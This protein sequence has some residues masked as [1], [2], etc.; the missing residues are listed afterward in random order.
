MVKGLTQG[1]NS[2]SSGG[3][4]GIWTHDLLKNN[5]ELLVSESPLHNFVLGF[6]T[7]R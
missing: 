1:R 7:R 3:S 6:H 5:S 2:D 4:A